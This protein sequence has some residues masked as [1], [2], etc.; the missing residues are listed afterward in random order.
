M[1]SVCFLGPSF[2]IKFLYRHQG[3]IAV[4]PQV[5]GTYSRIEHWNVSIVIDGSLNYN[6]SCCS[7]VAG[8]HGRAV[9]KTIAGSPQPFVKVPV[10][11]SARTL[12]MSSLIIYLLWVI[13]NQRDNNC[14]TVVL[15]MVMTISL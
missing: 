6:N 2:Y 10:F 9:G 13:L 12:L 5:D 4:Y 15:A 14:V 7:K 8:N 1:L 3:D 11:W